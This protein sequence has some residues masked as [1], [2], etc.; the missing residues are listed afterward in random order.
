MSVAPACEAQIVLYFRFTRWIGIITINWR[1]A[2]QV[3]FDYLAVLRRRQYKKWSIENIGKMSPISPPWIFG[4][5]IQDLARSIDSSAFLPHANVVSCASAFFFLTHSAKK[6]P[7]L[8]INHQQCTTINK[9]KL[10]S[11]ETPKRMAKFSRAK[12]R[13]S[14]KDTTTS[15]R[16]YPINT[17]YGKFI[18]NAN[19]KHANSCQPADQGARNLSHH[20]LCNHFAERNFSY[21]QPLLPWR[22]PVLSWTHKEWRPQKII[23]AKTSRGYLYLRY[24]TQ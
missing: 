4:W 16:Y 3:A 21:G 11:N 15:Q 24:S 23:H 2:C 5:T 19:K 10:A 1:A 9:C 6:L 7:S 22:I 14:H 13:H 20:D 12:T 17:S 8:C 18:V